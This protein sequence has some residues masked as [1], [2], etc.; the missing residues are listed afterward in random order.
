MKRLVLFLWSI[1]VVVFCLTSN[2]SQAQVSYLRT[3][4]DQPV[5]QDIQDVQFDTVG[6]IWV[7]SEGSLTRIQPDGTW[8]HIVDGIKPLGYA[9]LCIGPDNTVYFRR[10]DDIYR[11]KSGTDFVEMLYHIETRDPNNWSSHIAVD[12]NSNVYYADSGNLYKIVPNGSRV[13]QMSGLPT[14]VEHTSFDHDGNL[15]YTTWLDAWTRAVGRSTPFGVHSTLLLPTPHPTDL[16]VTPDNQIFAID[17]AG[18][19][20]VFN[21]EKFVASGNVAGDQIAASGFFNFDYDKLG[22]PL[23]AHRNGIFHFKLTGTDYYGTDDFQGRREFNR[24]GKPAQIRWFDGQLIAN[25]TYGDF[26]RLDI[27]PTD[28]LITKNRYAYVD[29]TWGWLDTN[30]ALAISSTGD[31]AFQSAPGRQAGPRATL[32][33]MPWNFEGQIGNPTGNF[34]GSPIDWLLAQGKQTWAQSMDYDR[35]GNLW[36]VGDY[37]PYF[38]ADSKRMLTKVTSAGKVTY[39]NFPPGLYLKFDRD[40]QMHV[41]GYPGGYANPYFVK[42][43]QLDGSWRLVDRLNGVGTFAFDDVGNVYSATPAE[44]FGALGGI[45]VTHPDG[46]REYFAESGTH[47]GQLPYTNFDL[48]LDGFGHLYTA[49]TL[50]SRI[51][52]WDIPNSIAP[53]PSTAFTTVPESN[54]NI[55]ANSDVVVKMVAN[56]S[57]SGVGVREVRYSIAGAP[58]SAVPG[59]IATFPTYIEGVIPFEFYAIGNDGVIESKK[60]GLARIDKTAPTIESSFDGNSVTLSA[61]DALSG[62]DYV[63]YQIDK[64]E[65]VTVLDRT[66]QFTVAPGVARVMFWTY[67]L[68]GNKSEEKVTVVTKY[69]QSVSVEPEGQTASV[70]GGKNADVV[71]KLS[72]PAPAGGLDITLTVTKPDL[73]PV[74]AVVTVPAGENG[75][76]V[77]VKSSIPDLATQISVTAK[78]DTVEVSTYFLLVNLEISQIS[79]PTTFERQQVTGRLY[80]RTPVPAGGAVVRLSSSNP[81]IVSVPNEVTVLANALYVDF[82]CQY[83]EVDKETT[84]SVAADVAGRIT[85]GEA[86]VLDRHVSKFTLSPSSVVGGNSVICEVSIGAPAPKS[87]VIIALSTG[88]TALPLPNAV[89]IQEGET[90]ARVTLSSRHVAEDINVV[91]SAVWEGSPTTATLEVLRN[92]IAGL[93]AFPSEVVGGN[94]SKLTVELAARAPVG[95]TVIPLVSDSSSVTSPATITVPAGSKFGTATLTSKFVAGKTVVKITATYNGDNPTAQLIVQPNGLVS[96]EATPAII[97]GGR[98]GE[99]VVAITS[100]APVGGR[101]ISIT[102]SNPAV[103]VPST[104]LIPAGAKAAGFKF[105]TKNVLDQIEVTVT[106]SIDGTSLTQKVTLT[107]SSPLVSVGVTPSTFDSGSTVQVKILKKVTLEP[108]SK[109]SISGSFGTLEQINVPGNQTEVLFDNIVIEGPPGPGRVNAECLDTTISGVYTI[110]ALSITSI[111]LANPNIFERRTTVGTVTLNNRAPSG[112]ATINLLSSR[113]EV[114]VPSTVT[115]QP[116]STFVSFEVSTKST[117]GDLNVTVTATGPG[118]S[119]VTT[120]RVIDIVQPATISMAPAVLGSSVA[121]KVAKTPTPFA[122]NQ[123]VVTLPDGTPIV[124]DNVAGDLTSVSMGEFIVSGVPGKQKITTRFE[125]EDVV[126]EFNVVKNFIKT[127]QV[128]PDILDE[129]Q[130]STGTVSLAYPAGVGGVVVKLRSGNAAVTVPASI[131]IP[132]GQISATYT[133]LTSEVTSSMR[134]VITAEYEGLSVT[135]P[136]TVRNITVATKIAI[137]LGPVRASYSRGTTIDVQIQLTDALRTTL[138]N[139]TVIVR[140]FVNTNQS[141]EVLGTVITD[142]QGQAKLRYTIPVDPLMDNIYI[143]ATYDGNPN[144]LR[145][146]A[147]KASKRI[148]IALK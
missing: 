89:K 142:A 112:G 126:S 36:L 6:N 28:P 17:A 74:P 15:W 78:Q 27:I 146:G 68:A 147:S 138:S 22:V 49:D 37:A 30:T 43:R 105:Q 18:G 143:E 127:L 54:A 102:A 26:I 60:Q 62:V 82:K 25:S 34:N 7:T 73:F 19:R 133:I 118:A 120:A 141:P 100:P 88:H 52:V 106:V 104:L 31:I 5:L 41:S 61:T 132:E 103:V 93:Y 128:S 57:R 66:A 32:F 80:F 1:F 131:I 116:G 130:S 21:G 92:K 58:E 40:G 12:K 47:P 45:R 123:L 94:S 72:Q 110:N 20:Y 24:I 137:T 81:A 33:Q 29:G 114:V 59:P 4:P 70:V 134:A 96:F 107:P 85:S 109:I 76:R 99:G 87:G 63:Q 115:I 77:T 9:G 97:K 148:P 69:L 16:Q 144:Q 35:F 42:V 135:K 129:T 90:S 119:K 71:I 139:R 124:K 11:V 64:N 95:G 117:I 113:A 13:I 121:V 56:S 67:D 23:L 84:V 50:G 3:I 98:I 79:L 48:T 111:T 14:N 122:L 136:V 39:A 51:Q 140:R 65:V 145:N 101:R 91:A 10:V 108:V 44:G 55:W 38:N 53:A 83:L 75:L 2:P 125:T 8:K 86:I 46:S